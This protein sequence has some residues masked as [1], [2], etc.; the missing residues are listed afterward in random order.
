ML[1]WIRR[2]AEQPALKPYILE[3]LSPGAAVQSDD[4]IMIALL[5]RGSTAFHVAGTC[6]MGADDASVVDP[7][8]R[9]RGVQGLRVCDTS[10]FPSLVS[11][12]TSAP[13]MATALRLAQIM[14]AE[15]LGL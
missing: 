6:R 14:K 5:E 15:P 8:L 1:R 13:A 2:L 7:H 4:E 9:V 3:E 11:G 12:N 10:V